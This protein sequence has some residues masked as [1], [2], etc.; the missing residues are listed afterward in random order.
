MTALIHFKLI[1][2]KRSKL[3][4][5]ALLQQA[6]YD[7]NMTYC[8]KNIS[9]KWGFMPEREYRKIKMTELKGSTSFLLENNA[10]YSTDISS[11]VWLDVMWCEANKCLASLLWAFFLCERAHLFS[12]SHSFGP[13]SSKLSLHCSLAVSLQSPKCSTHFQCNQHF[14]M[15]LSVAFL[16]RKVDFFPH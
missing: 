11:P 9:Q 10:H 2:V 16:T 4:F 8:G 3:Q 13:F 1:M 6:K 12:S 5:C 7:W 15:Y 14:W